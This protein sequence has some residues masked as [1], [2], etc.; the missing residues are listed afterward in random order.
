MKNKGEKAYN[1]FRHPLTC[2]F[3]TCHSHVYCRTGLKQQCNTHKHGS[4]V[5]RWVWRQTHVECVCLSVF[6]QDGKGHRSDISSSLHSS[7]TN[8]DSWS[9]Q[10]PCSFSSPLLAFFKFPIWTDAQCMVFSCACLLGSLLCLLAAGAGIQR[11]YHH[12]F[13]VFQL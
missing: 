8:T 7:T 1:H 13:L 2:W 5:N 4:L 9:A 3:S 12:R 10:T 11:K 6:G